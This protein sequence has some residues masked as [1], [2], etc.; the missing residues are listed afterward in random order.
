MLGLT[1][2]SI[3]TLASIFGH[4]KSSLSPSE[5]ARLPSGAQVTCPKQNGFGTALIVPSSCVGPTHRQ[6]DTSP[7]GVTDVYAYNTI[8]G[9]SGMAIGRDG[10]IWISDPDFGSLGP[11][12]HQLSI[13]GTL[14][15]VSLPKLDG[16]P[17]GIAAGLDGSIWVTLPVGFYPELRG[18]DRLVRI[19]PTGQQKIYSIPTANGWP[20]GIVVDRP[21]NVWFTESGDVGK[22]GERFVNGSYREIRLGYARSEPGAIALSD[23]GSLWFVEEGNNTIGFIDSARHLHEIRVAPRSA[24]IGLS[25]I[26]VDSAG[27]AWFTESRANSIGRMDNHGK[28]KIYALPKVSGL[29]GITKGPDRAMWFTYFNGIGRI[30]RAGNISKYKSPVDGLGP[31]I[32]GPDNNLWFVTGQP[33]ATGFGEWAGVGR[34]VIR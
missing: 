26:A 24:R 2:F 13:D 18:P 3:L 6:Y 16:G 14:R 31:L 19:L 5:N 17:E 30:D 27:D 22:I 21:G 10:K 1:C 15:D 33:G 7:P 4:D 12:V 34:F 20:V 23:N 9:G 11:R 32:T 29:S 25:G 8:S 28:F